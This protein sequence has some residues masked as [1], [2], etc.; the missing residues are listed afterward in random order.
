MHLH[1]LSGPTLSTENAAFVLAL[2][3][4]E[5]PASLYLPEPGDFTDYLAPLKEQWHI[6]ALYEETPVAWA[7]SFLRDERRWFA[8]IVDSR[9]HRAGMGSR[10]LALLKAQ[11]NSLYG[12]VVDTDTLSKKDGTPYSSPLP[13][14]LKNGFTIVENERL[15]LPHLTCA[16][17]YW[18]VNGDFS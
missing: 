14:Y 13:F 2:W 18:Q 11:F 12:W 5:Y 17:I 15:E 6:I 10:M 1:F 16:C 9:H 7:F 4:R 8:I 3:N